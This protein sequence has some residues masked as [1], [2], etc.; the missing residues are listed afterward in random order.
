MYYSYKKIN[1]YNY[2]NYKQFNANF[3]ELLDNFLTSS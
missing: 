3:I 1:N 2:Y